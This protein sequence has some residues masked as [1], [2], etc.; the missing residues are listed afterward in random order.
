MPD[1]TEPTPDDPAADGPPPA[2]PPD[3]ISDPIPG[4]EPRIPVP[5]MDP[6]EPSA[7]HGTDE[8][9]TATD[10]VPD[11]TDIGSDTESGMGSEIPNSPED[12]EGS[13][14]GDRV[15]I[16]PSDIAAGHLGT[17]DLSRDHR[18]QE[19]KDREREAGDTIAASQA[20]ERRASGESSDVD[21]SDL[22]GLEDEEQQ[23]DPPA[24]SAETTDPDQSKVATD[25]PT[26]EGS[27]LR[28][29]GVGA[30][31]FMVAL[32]GMWYLMSNGDS[33]STPGDVTAGENSAAALDEGSGTDDDSAIGGVECDKSSTDG[34]DSRFHVNCVDAMLDRQGMLWI[35]F[36]QGWESTPPC[37]IKSGFWKATATYN[38]TFEIGWET[39]DGVETLLGT[40]LEAYILDNGSIVFATG[41][42]P[43]PPFQLDIE[44]MFASWLT[45]ADPVVSG[46]YSI[47]IGS[48]S[49]GTG[50]PLA[51][52]GGKPVFDLTASKP[53][54][55]MTAP[56]ASRFKSHT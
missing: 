42:S 49:I 38:P 16:E 47:S 50:D 28:K 19:V 6:A 23:D 37:C 3:H 30:S 48:D 8:E 27:R 32:F 31:L 44:V 10:S 15:H 22:P 43:A 2:P 35:S 13:A 29:V 14:V 40:P 34:V 52:F 33:G 54:A 5:D 55:G 11:L 20:E 4:R 26:T 18:S 7:E 46:D 45:E 51:D 12:T 25:T 53:L 39:H 21:L 36:G 56:S 9:I 1:Q 41:H 17:E 24:D